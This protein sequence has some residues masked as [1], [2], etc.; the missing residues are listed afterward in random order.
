VTNALTQVVGF[1]AQ[2]RHFVTDLPSTSASVEIMRKID[3]QPKVNDMLSLLRSRITRIRFRHSVLRARMGS[4]EAARRA[5][6]KPATVA[7][8]DSVPTAAMSES[9]S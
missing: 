9:G 3:M 1:H 7:H 5:G 4:I 2:C 8:R 6:S